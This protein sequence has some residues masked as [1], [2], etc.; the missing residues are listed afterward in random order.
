MKIERTKTVRH[1]LYG[2]QDFDALSGIILA[3]R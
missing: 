3:Q 1:P 2:M